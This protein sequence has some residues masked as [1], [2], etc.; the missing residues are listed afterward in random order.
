MPGSISCVLSM[1]RSFQKNF[2]LVSGS[3]YGGAWRLL[4]SWDFSVINEKAI[5]NHKNNLA[6]QLKVWSYRII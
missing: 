6:I 5:Q 1:A 3:T 4:C 2:V